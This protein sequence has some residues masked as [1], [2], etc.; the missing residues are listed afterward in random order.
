MYPIY[1][2]VNNNTNVAVRLKRESNQ[3]AAGKLYGNCTAF[4]Y[5]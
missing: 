4:H 3:K 2:N 5:H 1:R